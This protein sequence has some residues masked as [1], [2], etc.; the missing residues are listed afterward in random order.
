MFSATCCSTAGRAFLAVFDLYGVLSSGFHKVNLSGAINLSGA[1]CKAMYKSRLYIKMCFRPRFSDQV[2][3]NRGAY[4]QK[5][6]DLYMESA[7]RCCSLVQARL[8][9]R[10]SVQPKRAP[11][12]IT[13]THFRPNPGGCPFLASSVHKS[14]AQCPCPCTLRECTLEKRHKKHPWSAFNGFPGVLWGG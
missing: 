12:P 11:C 6:R 9:H 2:F 8:V 14:T 3:R 10:S 7:F 4:R 1:V 5:P 13:C